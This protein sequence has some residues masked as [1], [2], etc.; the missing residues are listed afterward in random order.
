M[1]G[2]SNTVVMTDCNYAAKNIQSQLVL[3]SDIVTGGSAVFDVG[4]LCLAGVSIDLYQVNDY[5]SD[6]LVL[7]LYS[8]D[9]INKLMNLVITSIKDPLNIAFVAVTL[10]F[11]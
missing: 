3:G 1:N 11:L 2:N 4:I 6:V 5:A 8:S 9:T 7:K 10:Y